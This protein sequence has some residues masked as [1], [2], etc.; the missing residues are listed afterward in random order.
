METV[1]MFSFQLGYWEDL[2]WAR[3]VLLPQRMY[4]ESSFGHH[5]DLPW[6]VAANS[7][8]MFLI[9]SKVIRTYF[10]S[11]QSVA[12]SSEIRC[13]G[14]RSRLVRDS[15]HEWRRVRLLSV[16]QICSSGLDQLAWIQYEVSLRFGQSDQIQR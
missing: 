6:R 11:R 15:T 14:C 5:L 12:L 1:V 7:K 4:M 2:L 8:V 10:A 3:T 16:T 9:L 13:T